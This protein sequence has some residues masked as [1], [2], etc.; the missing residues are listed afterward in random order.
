M[1]NLTLFSWG[2]KGWGN[3]I[4]ELLH[5]TQIAE[6]NRGFQPPVF[7]DIR[8]RR[9]V[10]AEGFREKAFERVL[11]SERYVW[12]NDLGNANIGNNNAS[13]PRISNPSAAN[14]LLD[15]AI[16]AAKKKQRV[17]FFCSCDCLDPNCHR[18]IVAELT[19]KAAKERKVPITITAWPGGVPS[20]K[21]LESFKITPTLFKKLISDT[22]SGLP[23]DATTAEQ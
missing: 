6:Q 19:L 22:F 16:N 3:A 13:K 5:S 7:V 20:K 18:H 12:M 15:L 11:G 14:E 9:A 23:I 21:T 10:R 8:F 1:K 4:P 2:Y 17:V